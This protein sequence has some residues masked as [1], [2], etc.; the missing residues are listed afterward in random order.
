M[1][2]K[3]LTS[4]NVISVLYT[5]D[6]VIKDGIVKSVSLP[7]FDSNYLSTTPKMVVDVEVS[8]NGATKLFTMPE[9]SETVH[10][11]SLVITT[12][13]SSLKNEVEK[14]KREA[15]ATLSTIDKLKERVTLSSQLLASFEG[16]NYAVKSLEDR[17]TRLEEKI[18]N[19]LS[20][21]EP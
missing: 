16:S 19:M 7:H 5:D 1:K 11:E 6:V 4:G 12:S 8:I 21:N 20:K 14:I 9:D 18:E 2:F 17:L 13:H 10:A 15:E 3:E